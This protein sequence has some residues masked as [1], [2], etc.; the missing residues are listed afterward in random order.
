MTDPYKTHWLIMSLSRCRV[1]RRCTYSDT[2]VEMV[3][4]DHCDDPIKLNTAR[5]CDLF[6]RSI[7]CYQEDYF[8]NE[9]T[10]D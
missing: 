2:N 9:I 7:G 1:M 5:D 10:G 3:D 4:I 8:L 6:L